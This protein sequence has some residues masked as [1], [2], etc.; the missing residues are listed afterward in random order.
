MRESGF[1]VETEKDII[2]IIYLQNK[3]DKATIAKQRQLQ[4]KK[5]QVLEKAKT[6]GL[7]DEEIK[8]LKEL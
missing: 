3:T 5:L 6:L 7:S 2:R 4:E 8:I 1:V